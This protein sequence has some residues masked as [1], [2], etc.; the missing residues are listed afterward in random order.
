[1][2]CFIGIDLGSTTPKAVVVEDGKTAE[3]RT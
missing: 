2:R 3:A 1:M